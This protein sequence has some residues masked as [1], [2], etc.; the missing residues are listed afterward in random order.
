MYSFSLVVGSIYLFTYFYLEN[1]D[2]HE[3]DCFRELHV[4]THR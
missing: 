4:L 3:L 2:E 1:G